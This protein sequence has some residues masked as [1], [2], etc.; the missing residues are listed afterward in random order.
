MKDL[1]EDIKRLID[2]TPVL[3]LQFGEDTCGP[4]YAIRAR[5]DQWL[6]KHEGIKA[7]YV[8]IEKNLERC[9]QM[10]IFSVPTVMA[11]IDGQL[12]AR[13][14]GYFSLDTMLKRI[15]RYHDLRD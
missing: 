11:Y 6:D 13:Q 4:C 10:E 15:D 1:I 5:L 7:R 12:V 8:D 14:S 9:S 3:I 2:S